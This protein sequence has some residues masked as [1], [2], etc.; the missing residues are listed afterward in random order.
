MLRCLNSIHK[1]LKR[2]KD[3]IMMQSFE[4]GTEKT[5]QSKSEKKIEKHLKKKKI[6]GKISEQTLH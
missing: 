5:R 3:K 4:K 1:V 2:K 6:K